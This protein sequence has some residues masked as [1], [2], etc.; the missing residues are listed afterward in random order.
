MCL[1]ISSEGS[2]ERNKSIKCGKKTERNYRNEDSST[3]LCGF[4]KTGASCLK[5]RIEYGAPFPC[6]AASG[7]EPAAFPGQRCESTAFSSSTVD[8]VATPARTSEFSHLHSQP[9]DTLRS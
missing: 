9:L 8:L 3:W 6:A 7:N 1:A 5:Q 4:S 2:A